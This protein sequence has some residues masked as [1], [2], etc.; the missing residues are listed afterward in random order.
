MRSI[1]QRFMSGIW[2]CG[3]APTKLKD[4]SRAGG[5]VIRF[6]WQPGKRATIQ[7]LDWR[8]LRERALVSVEL[9]VVGGWALHLTQPYLNVDPTVIV[10]GGEFL[11][12]IPT[13]HFWTRFRECGTCALWNGSFM[14][15]Y[16]A[17]AEFF[18]SGLH[19]VVAFTTL[20]WGVVNGSKLTMA[21][22]FVMAG[23]A[24]WWLARLLGLGWV[25]RV[26]S[27]CAA[28]AAG[29]LS[30]RAVDGTMGL[31]LSV[32]A[33]S[34][35]VPALLWLARSLS[36]RS[37]VTLAVLLAQAAFAGQ[38]YMQ[39]ALA[40]VLPTAVFLVSWDRARLQLLAQRF[41]VSLLLA[42]LLAAPLFLPAVNFLPEFSK[43]AAPGFGA[44]Q[45]LGLVPLN[46][47]I[48]DHGF[49]RSE[50]L[51]KVAFPWMNALYVGWIPVVFAA[52]ALR[53]RRNDERCAVLFLAVMAALG[54][55][56]ASGILFMWVASV[57]PVSWIREALL[58]LR[59]FPTMGG[60]AV[61]PIL[62]LSAIGVDRL[63]R[64]AW[65]RI[66][67]A[68]ATDLPPA[69]SWVVDARVLLAAPLL[70]ALLD[71]RGF[72]S[73]WLLTSQQSQ[74]HLPVL[75][76]LRT[77]DLQ[78]VST[79]VDQI[80]YMETGAAMGL[81]V[82]HPPSNWGWKGRAR[83]E[84]V[85]HAGESNLPPNMT[86][87][88][89]VAGVPIYA[90]GPG[91]EYA[92]MS[93]PNGAR[94]IC[95]ASGGGADID[96]RCNASGVGTLTVKENNWRGWQAWANGQAVPLLPGDWLAVDVG[97]GQS[98]VEFRYRP[99]DVPLGL[100]LFVLGIGMCIFFWVKPDHGATP[101]LDPA[102]V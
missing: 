47:V 83:P 12:N 27:G 46:L 56:L 37:A 91:R 42:F 40:L 57:S 99:W 31:L 102:P 48:N 39:V 3:E 90:S 5:G 94:T 22:A 33:C 86:Q 98:T 2:S 97:A 64:A 81:K 6:P 89:T 36:Y 16:P 63:A 29:H 100:G 62:G 35:A 85:L 19:P 92:A 58:G 95:S 44:G 54:M 30:S 88:S 7:Q 74:E 4:V 52:W 59:S 101:V 21:A 10:P 25:A 26:W 70:L 18:G 38:G 23:F 69:R 32:A 41:S 72:S 55:V 65:P 75:E 84:A 79:P 49:Y 80:A 67:I 43:A 96:V 60:L 34:L 11:R 15:G 50:V 87:I 77:P 78:W 9:L 71:L 20:G 66:R 73:S 13:H 93:H 8:H 17:L 53:G 1:R 76:A 28:V 82:P 45:P 24:Q 14:G 61:P 51:R 68:A